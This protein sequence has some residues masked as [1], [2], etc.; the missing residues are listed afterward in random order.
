MIERR[1]L[2]S[3]L[4]RRSDG[5]AIPVAFLLVWL[6]RRRVTLTFE[7]ASGNLDRPTQAHVQVYMPGD[8]AVRYRDLDL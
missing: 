1:S 8:A 4:E 7:P 2:G 6:E 3:E 5:I